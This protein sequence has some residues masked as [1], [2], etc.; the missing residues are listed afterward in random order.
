MHLLAVVRFQSPLNQV[1]Q[2]DFAG[3]LRIND[4]GVGGRWIS[5]PSPPAVALAKALTRLGY[6]RTFTSS[7]RVVREGPSNA[8]APRGPGAV[9]PS[10]YSPDLT[11]APMYFRTRNRLNLIKLSGED[12]NT[13]TQVALNR[14]GLI[15]NLC[16][17][18]RPPAVDMS[19][20]GHFPMWDEPQ[21]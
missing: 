2:Y 14:L 5:V 1:A 17:Q 20:V 3:A 21:A 7:S 11:T 4:L 8:P 13:S 15:S 18:P 19:V 6:G 16:P 12:L 10:W 9:S